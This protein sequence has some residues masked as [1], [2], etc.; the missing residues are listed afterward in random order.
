[1]WSK[2]TVLSSEVQMFVKLAPCVHGFNSTMEFI[3][4]THSLSKISEVLEGPP[5]GVG[6]AGRPNLDHIKMDRD[7]STALFTWLQQLFDVVLCSSHQSD[8]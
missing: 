2:A 5:G 8:R 4:K 6:I 7:F 1:M 3:R